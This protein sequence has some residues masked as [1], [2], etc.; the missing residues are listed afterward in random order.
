MLTHF[1]L[2]KHGL[3]FG[4]GL[5]VA[6]ARGDIVLLEHTVG[7]HDLADV[8]HGG[9]QIGHA[10]GV[11]Q[12]SEEIVAAAFLHGANAHTQ[13]LQL[14]FL[15]F[16]GRVNLLRLFVD[17]RVVEL[18]LL[19]NQRKLLGGDGVSLVKRFLLL[20]G[21]GLLLLELIDFRLALLLPGGKL[22]TLGLHFVNV[23]L[24]HAIGCHRQQK[25]QHKQHRDENGTLL[26]FHGALL[27]ST[28]G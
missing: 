16:S 10:V 13:A 11:H 9:K 27:T 19:L 5:L 4:L 8:I 22:L 1:K 6:L 26:I 3:V 18:D 2:L 24:R 17:H 12:Q 28:K 14:L 20:D 23:A 15:G 21:A 25:Q 7:L